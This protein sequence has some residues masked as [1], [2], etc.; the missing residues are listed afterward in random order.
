M[1]NPQ[2]KLTPADDSREALIFGICDRLFD[3]GHCV[4]NV[5]LAP[6]RPDGT[7]DWEHASPAV[8]EPLEADE[9]PADPIVAQRA[10]VI[11]DH[12]DGCDKTTSMLVFLREDGNPSV[13]QI[14]G[15]DHDADIAMRIIGRDIGAKPPAIPPSPLKEA[16]EKLL[17]DLQKPAPVAANDNKPKPAPETAGISLM[18]FSEFKAQENSTADAVIKGLVRTG[19]LIAIGGRP[20]AG[21][22]ALTLAMGNALDAGEPFLGRETKPTTVVIIAAEDGGD[23]AN[24]LEAMGNDRIKIAKLPEG[25]PLTKPPKAAAVMREVVRQAKALDPER[26]VMVVVDTLRAALGGVSVLEDKTTSPALNA[27]REV[28]EAEGAVIAILNHTNRENNKATKG[29]TLEAVAALEIVLLEGEGDWFTVYVGKNRSGPGHRNIGKVRY[30]SAEVGGVSA[31]VVDELVA[32]ENISDGPKERGPSGNAK[33]L[34]GIIQTAILETTETRRPFGIEGPEV[35]VVAVEAVRASFYDR[36]EGSTDTKLK[37]F[38]RAMTHWI[39]KQW[40]VRG[41]GSEGGLLWLASVRD[42]KGGQPDGHSPN[43]ASVRPVR[44]GEDGRT[45]QVDRVCPVLSGS[46]AS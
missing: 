42:E 28:A 16:S 39:D 24:R 40:I 4:T 3:H 29:E 19:T 17:A 26:H 32:D 43:Q 36:K 25:L 9:W 45:G 46:E 18:S 12:I 41:E 22:T 8:L 20:G 37:A 6:A 7:P 35:K 23:V 27:L 10:A 5:V 15:P 11:V 2:P 33:I 31:A 21:K 1:Q 14:A 38:N 34:H 13:E 30:T 44:L